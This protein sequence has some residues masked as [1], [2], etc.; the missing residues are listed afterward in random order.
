MSVIAIV[1]MGPLVGLSVAR[2]WGRQ[3]YKVAMISRTQ[4]KLDAYAKDLKGEG[5]ESRG[6]SADVRDAAS[7]NAAYAAI[8]LDFGAIDV[9]EYSPTEWVPGKSYGP[10]DTTVESATDH[11]NLLVAGA[12]TSVHAVLPDMAAKGKGALLFCTGTSAHG[13]MPFITSL[14]ISN[15]G[16]RNYVR[17][18]VDELKLKG[19]YVGTLSIGVGIQRDGTRNDPD[20]IVDAIYDMF[21]KQ[22]RTDEI[23]A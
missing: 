18:L 22:D 7:L 1:G 11:F 4:S 16:L 12:I 10:L 23:W 8:K 21:E 13:P 5:I 14:A 20:R 15:A 3:G 19:I 6:Y 17:C 9:L 2:K